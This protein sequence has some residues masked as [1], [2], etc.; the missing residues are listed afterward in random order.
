MQSARPDPQQ[1]AILIAR[2]QTPPRSSF[3]KKYTALRRQV[4]LADIDFSLCLVHRVL[5][6]CTF[7]GWVIVSAEGTP[8]PHVGI[9]NKSSVATFP[10]QVGFDSQPAAQWARGDQQRPTRPD[11]LSSRDL[12]RVYACGV[13]HVAAPVRLLP[14]LRKGTPARGPS[15]RTRAIH[16]CG[17]S[18]PVL[19]VT[20]PSAPICLNLKVIIRSF[21]KLTSASPGR[22]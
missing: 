16:V 5:G 22:L 6:V 12:A 10:F 7:L 19:M 3:F 4:F 1:P 2:P 14:A 15:E 18:C 17:K 20:P 21:L 8:K 9:R 11:C 13:A